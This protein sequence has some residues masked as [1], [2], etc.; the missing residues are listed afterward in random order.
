MS[1]VTPR[2]WAWFEGSLVTSEENGSIPLNS[3]VVLSADDHRLE[4]SDD[5]SA[6]IVKCVNMHEELVRALRDAYDLNFAENGPTLKE[7]EALLAKAE[8][9]E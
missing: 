9:D 8:A 7:I 2:P 6:H 5:D 3:R 4:I 1:K